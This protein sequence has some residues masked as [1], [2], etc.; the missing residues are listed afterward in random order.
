[1]PLNFRQYPF[2]LNGVLALGRARVL[3]LVHLTG[4]SL[5]GVPN[6]PGGIAGALLNHI[7]TPEELRVHLTPADLEIIGAKHGIKS[8]T[9]WNQETLTFDEAVLARLF[10]ERP[11]PVIP[12][13]RP[14]SRDASHAAAWPALTT[15]ATWTAQDTA[16]QHQT[17]QILAHALGPRYHFLDFVGPHHLAR[18]QDE[19]LNLPFLAIPGGSFTMGLADA[20][21][22]ALT[23]LIKKWSEEA[24]LHA[25]DLSEL[26][27]PAHAVTL[28]PFLCA[29]T[30][31]TPAQTLPQGTPL[32]N[33][34]YT[35]S[36][37][38]APAALALTRQSGT[39][40]L[41]EA[42]WEY[43]ARVG[44]LRTWLSADEPPET[45][46]ARVLAAALSA[47]DGHPFGVY[48]LGW[49][50]RVEDS[51]H[52]S[53]RNAPTDGSAWEPREVPEVVRGGAFLSWPWQTDGEALLLHA[54]HR[55]RVQTVFPLLLARD[56]P[57]RYNL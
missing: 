43:L 31:L 24:R 12:P 41:T 20:E 42:E 36:L 9:T 52:S 38:D 25:R 5:K 21:K 34:A 37:Y 14:S 51:W 47:G 6:Y 7:A 57:E 11:L 35:L 39:R 28:P 49:G 23:R 45:Y 26:S 30:P 4:T 50:S 46:T 10:E 15:L 19:Q 8:R 27:R 29:Q 17:A 53:Y 32:S 54:A 3:E 1:M 44:E 18:L 56:L 13:L 2:V 16:T 33:G 40:L 55:E 48:G 22:R